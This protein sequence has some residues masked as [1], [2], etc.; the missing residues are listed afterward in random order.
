[1]IGIHEIVTIIGWILVFIGF[2]IALFAALLTLLSA[3]RVRG[4]GALL[5]GPFPIIFGTNRESL[6]LVLILTVIVM[7]FAFFLMLLSY[8]LVR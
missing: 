5:I 3:T 7:F 2:L 6:K 1:M 4:G 8:V